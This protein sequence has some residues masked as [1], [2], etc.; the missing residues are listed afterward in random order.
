MLCEKSLLYFGYLSAGHPALV[1][2]ECPTNL[3]ETK[4][5]EK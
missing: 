3:R 4:R 2:H 5:P 1:R